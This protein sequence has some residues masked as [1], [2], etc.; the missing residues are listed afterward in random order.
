MSAVAS[1]VDMK[2][3]SFVRAWA[4][5]SLSVIACDRQTH[6]EASDEH[7][8]V[9]TTSA[10][11][12]RPRAAEASKG[13]DGAPLEACGD[14]LT[15]PACD[16]ACASGSSCGFELYCHG[17]GSVYGL[18]TQGAYLYEGTVEGSPD[19]AREQ[20][21][22]WIATHEADLGLAAGL[23]ESHVEL[24]PAH[25][26]HQRMGGL[27]VLRFT[28]TYRSLPVLPPDDLVQV[29]HTGRG[30]VQLSGRIVDA[31]VDYDDRA[32]WV[33][34]ESAAES[35]RYHTHV[36]TQR[37]LEDIVVNGPTMV[38]IPEAQTIAWMGHA[39]HAGGGVLARVIVDGATASPGG[40]LMLSSYRR[41]QVEDL[42]ATVPI[43]VLTVD[44]AS[45]PA[46]PSTS[47]ETTL[48]NGAPLLGSVDDVSG[49]VQL[50][51]EAVVVLDLNGGS[52]G[53][54][55]V[56][57]SRILDP[58]GMFVG[59]DDIALS[60]QTTYHLMSS[61]YA[62]LDALMT[63]P[64]GGTK[65]WDSAVPVYHAGPS[66]TPAGVFAPRMFAFIDSGPSDCSPTAVACTTVAG[67][68]PSS[69]QALVFPELA[70][71]PPGVAQ[72]DAEAVGRISL[73]APST[74]ANGIVTLAHELGH[75]VDLHA[76]PG[77]T[78]DIAPDCAGSCMLECIEDTSDEAPPLGESIAQLLAMA[79]L[80]EGFDPL[81]LDHCG[82]VGMLSRHN[83]K[84]FDPGPCVP[85]G[86]DVSVLE[87]P[88][89]CSKP[90]PY[91]DK[92]DEPGFSYECCDPAID[93]GCVVDAPTNCPATGFQRMVPTGLCHESPGYDTHS[94]LQ[95]FWQL[96]HGQRC[97]AAAPFECESAVWPGGVEPADA[98]VAALLYSL[99]LD[100][101][102]YEQ[103]IDGMAIYVACTHGANAYAEL[104]AVACAHGLRAC[105]EPP[106]VDCETCGNGVREGGETCDGLDWE[107]SSCAD[108]EGY[109]SGELHCNQVTC[110]LDVGHCMSAED[111]GLDTTDGQRSTDGLE[112]TGAATTDTDSATAGAADGGGCR[113]STGDHRG[114]WPLAVLVCQY[115][116]RRREGT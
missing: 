82:V 21:V 16:L 80:R 83:V 99:R 116:R 86:E 39:T 44:P 36:R 63:D 85:A 69:A 15:G 91:C 95:A 11:L 45:D 51:T 42:A 107:R 57:G 72:G 112:T 60:G 18:A 102:S 40:P 25:G 97:E 47:V 56:V 5:L 9:S 7:V 10:S 26:L 88:A 92:P 33:S 53:D 52:V 79:A 37:P 70:H 77:F 103:L 54:I 50:A 94:L 113:C 101:L 41:T 93:A 114:L 78:I 13:C 108:I 22:S 71:Q 87:R 96:L 73:R 61:W 20:L 84:A 2:A 109:L 75:V 66:P 74:L 8:E 1:R 55:D 98:V 34:A 35:I 62:W 89:T 68:A 30:A 46:A 64:V 4:S 17:D 38:A 19:A 27:T 14:G 58:G 106:P 31:R 6:D 115:R 29:V 104:N 90:E 3:A 111:G 105:D 59:N 23:D 24:T 28:Q 49:E 65:R 48:V 67:Y 100:P 43:Q 81:E 110:R 32:S 76:G 12:V